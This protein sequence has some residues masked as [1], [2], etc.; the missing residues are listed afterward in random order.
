MPFAAPLCFS[1]RRLGI[2]RQLSASLIANVIALAYGLVI[3]WASPS[4]IILRNGEEAI[5][6]EEESWLGS[7]PFL[8]AFLS[9]VLYSY[10]NQ[11][12][13]R[14]AAGYLTAVP[15]IIGLGITAYDS[16]K[17][18]LYIARFI[19]GFGI[20]GV[21]VFVTM[22]VGE[23]SEDNFRGCLGN[24]RGTVADVG[25]TLMYIVGPYLSIRCMAIISVSLPLLFLFAYFWLP[26]SPMFL[27][28]K[29]R[30][31]EALDAYL[32][33]RGGD[34]QRAE[35]EME[36]LSAVVVTT[37]DSSD[38]VTVINLLSVL[39]TRRALEIA[40][41]LAFVQTFS[42][43]QFMLSYCTTVFQKVGGSV[44]PETSAII[45]GFI[46]TFGSLI[47]C[48]LA[49][50]VGRRPILI[51]TQILEAVCLLGLAAYLYVMHAGTDVSSWGV[52]PIISLSLF[53]FCVIVGP[54][55]F[56]YVLMSETFRP[57]ARGLAMSIAS[58]VLWLLS[59]ISSKFYPN[60][61]SI[62]G[63][64]GN[65]IFFGAVAL[66]GAVYTYRRIPET[67]NRSLEDILRELNGVSSV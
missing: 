22:Y 61:A 10:I 41:I 53:C 9:S 2:L 15:F 28:G 8:G 20:S 7:L 46:N 48:F 12:L 29:G 17:L 23:I 30:R 58:S 54:G 49:D 31:S 35:E 32:W 45:F 4:L 44:S 33:L 34:I 42:G 25:I 14:K 43:L 55:N 11:H 26:E 38:E 39:G 27:L 24:I 51:V 40:L 57:E 5:T 65:F 50:T 56:M 21:N 66:F 62:L 6:E 16:S 60:L 1:Q 52:L 37:K 13:G 63:F 47:S 36:K 64:Y 67:K 3:G 19:A 59:F 18:F